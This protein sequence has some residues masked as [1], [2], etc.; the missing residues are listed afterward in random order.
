MNSSSDDNSIFDRLA[1]G[2]LPAD[3]RRE[4]LSSLDE[5]TDGWRRCALALLEAQ[6]WRKEFNSLVRTEAP[7]TAVQ[8]AVAMPS[9]LPA[10]PVRVL[11]LAASTLLAF[12]LGWSLHTQSDLQDISSYTV[13]TEVPAVDQLNRKAD[14]PAE[15]IHESR[16]AVTL[17]V[18][19]VEGRH[20]R[21]Q[22]PLMKASALGDQWTQGPS[23]V[24]ADLRAGLQNR[25]LDVR[26]ERRYAPLFFEQGKGLVPMVI[27]VDDTYVVPVNRPVY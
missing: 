23:A 26:R 6:T 7:P 19:D 16:D 27:P 18:R 2:E 10:R 12:G 20:Q 3:E 25:G 5:R 13:K 11:V 22:L 17:V 21:V 1:D 8:V 4:L 14:L 15:K 24:P 9:Q